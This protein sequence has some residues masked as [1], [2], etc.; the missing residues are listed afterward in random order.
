MG[1]SVIEVAQ[2]VAGEVVEILVV[3]GKVDSR[4]E[5]VP[6]P[7][8][9]AVV[10]SLAVR[11]LEITL[12]AESQNQSSAA[13]AVTLA[14]GMI[15]RVG[16]LGHFHGLGLAFGLVIHHTLIISKPTDLV[17]VLVPTLFHV[18]IART[19]KAVRLLEVLLTLPGFMEAKRWRGN[20]YISRRV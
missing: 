8:A 7:L 6:E 19:G 17:T 9:P 18:G 5:I 20:G 14:I 13:I 12:A 16:L 4:E 3:F 15:V 11:A 1:Q 2:L 10:V